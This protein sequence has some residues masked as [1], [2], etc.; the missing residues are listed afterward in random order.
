MAITLPQI[1]DKLTAAYPPPN[2]PIIITGGWT[3]AC[4]LSLVVKSH[5]H[6]PGL[7]ASDPTETRTYVQ[8][9]DYMTVTLAQSAENAACATVTLAPTPT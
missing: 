5:A 1:P 9:M 2:A 7:I 6:A 4:T 8:E 3:A